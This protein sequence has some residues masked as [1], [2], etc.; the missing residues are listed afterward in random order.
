MTMPNFLIIGAAKSGTTA[1]HRYLTQHPQIFMSRRKEL[2]FFPFE[3]GR[4]DYRGPGDAADAASITTDIDEYRAQFD[5]SEAFPAR[6]E[7]SPLYLYMP[8]SAE[9]I[10]HYLPDAKLIAVLRHPA[11]RAFSQYLMIRRDG[12][13]TLG[14]AEALAAEDGRVA[15]GWGH[16]WHYRRRGF[17]AAQLK[18]YFERFSREQ[19]RCYLYEDFT[20]DPVGLTRDIFRFL[21]VDDSFV[22]D[23]TTRHNESKFPRI[24][25]LQVFLTEPRAAKNLLKPLLPAGSSRRIGDRLRR[26]NLTRPALSAEMR[27]RLIEVYR[28]DILELQEMLGRDLSGWLK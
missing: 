17:Y 19:L 8:Q 11:E 21:D 14:F 2:R 10:R 13:E 26:S 6:G 20:S 18:R 9:R 4:P 16:R 3:G 15:D 22:P 7:S 5:G 12:L 24:R 27:R 1:L 28:E 23:M 25:A